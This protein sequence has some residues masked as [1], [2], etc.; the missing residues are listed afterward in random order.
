MDEEL[1]ITV[2]DDKAREDDAEALCKWAAAGQA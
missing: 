2:I 1:K